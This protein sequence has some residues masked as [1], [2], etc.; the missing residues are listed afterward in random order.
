V[1][2][3]LFLWHGGLRQLPS[4]ETENAAPALDKEPINVGILFSMRGPMAGEGSAAHD[5]AQLAIDELNQQ[6]GLLGHP[7]VAIHCDGKSDSRI[8]AQ[9]AEKLITKDHVCAIFGTRTSSNR[10]AVLPIVQKHENLLFHPMQFEGLE[11][12][13][14]IIYL[15][16]APNQQILP[17]IDYM[18]GNQGK[19]RL[20]LVGSDYVFPRAANEILRY[21]VQRKYPGVQILDERYIPFGGSEVQKTIKAI[22]EKKP[23]LIVNTINGDTNSA[24]FRELY[25]AGVRA[26]TMPVL[27][28][29]VGENDLIGI[30]E[31]GVGHYA[32]WSYFQSVDREENREFVRKFSERFPRR[33]ISDPMETVYFGIQ[34]WAQAVQAAGSFEP[35]AVHEAIKGCSLEAPEGGVRID[36]DTRYT[37]RPMRIGRVQKDGQFKLVYQSG[38]ALRP[39]PFPSTRPRS[40]WE[41]FLRDLYTAWDDHWEA[42][43]NKR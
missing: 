26:D 29:S 6:G 37:W 34:L 8:F 32:A 14:N 27:S 3:G 4:A 23:D 24:F 10:K 20:F 19:H 31:P 39:E 13:P 38:W 30:G 1:G 7:I 5:A 25:E 41:R 11:D 33:V 12:S 9:E 21:H 15:G 18:L 40:E 28:F 35:N 17:A 22:Q 2:G 42:G 36:S 16:A 43:R